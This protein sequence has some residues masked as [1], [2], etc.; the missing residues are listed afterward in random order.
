M[1][2]ITFFS[3]NLLIIEC[4]S[5]RHAQCASRRVRFFSV[6]SET[7]VGSSM[8]EGPMV[9][10]RQTEGGTR[11]SCVHTEKNTVC[12]LKPAAF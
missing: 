3:Q 5:V 6:D 4:Q 2:D 9:G 8:M 12:K 10:F 11:G 7:I 1:I